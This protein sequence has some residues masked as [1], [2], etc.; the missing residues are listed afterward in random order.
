MSPVQTNV[1]AAEIERSP[2]T[3]PE[4]VFADAVEFLRRLGVIDYKAID[5]AGTIVTAVRLTDAGRQLL[6]SRPRLLTA[7]ISLGD[8]IV[9]VSKS[10]SKRAV[11]ETMSI[12]V[13]TIA[14]AGG[15]ALSLAM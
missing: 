11:E 4:G 6:D 3:D 7:N 9:A 10:G 2:D 5:E 1:A 13:R 15:I 12:I 14:N 8:H